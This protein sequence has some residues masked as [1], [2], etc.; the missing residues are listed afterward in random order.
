MNATNQTSHD[1]VEA[2]LADDDDDESLGKELIGPAPETLD[3]QLATLLP[4]AVKNKERYLGLL[5]VKT[6]QHTNPHGETFVFGQFGRRRPN[7]TMSTL[8]YLNPLRG[9]QLVEAAEDDLEGD[10]RDVYGKP[11][12]KKYLSLGSYSQAI[13]RE[14][15]LIPAFLS[16][17][18]DVDPEQAKNLQAEY[19][20]LT[21]DEYADFC[22]DTLI[23]ALQEYAPPYTYFGSHPGDGADFGVWVSHE[24]IDDDLKYGQLR[25]MQPDQEFVPGTGYVV[26]VNAAGDYVKLLDGRT[27]KEIW[28]I[29]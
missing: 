15:D 4:D 1:I 17:L 11:E 24:S 28:N 5:C 7:L 23:N 2:L 12:E 29:A 13:L 27:G 14:E 22:W 21:E 3:A 9:W 20:T 25:A 18:S 26:V 19:E 10:F 8:L 16:A 6:T